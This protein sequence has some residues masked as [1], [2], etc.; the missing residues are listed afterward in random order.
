MRRLVTDIGWLARQMYAMRGLVEVDVT[1]PRQLIHEHKEQTGETLSF[2]AFI[3]NCVAHAVAADKQLHAYRNWRG[4][5]VIFDD[6][7]I[8]T[9]VEIDSG[10]QKIPVGHIIR[11]ADKKTLRE[12]HDEIRAVQ[13][14]QMHSYEAQQVKSLTLL[15]AFIR[16]F[17]MWLVFHNPQLSKKWRGTVALTAVGMFGKHGGWGVPALTYTLGIT[18]G[19]I[20]QKP[21]VVDGHIEIRE[22]LSLTLDFDHDIVDGAPAARFAHQLIELIESGYG[23]CS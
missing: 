9:M 13:A 16:R 2:T 7:D 5:L 8:G 4:Q 23:L 1:K 17:L 19:G 18:V 20:G 22:Y 14:Q 10:E 21:G 12:I 6:V 11:G 3:A 15:P